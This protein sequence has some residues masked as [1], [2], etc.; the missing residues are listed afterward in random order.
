MAD[1]EVAIVAEDLGDLLGRADQRGGVAVG[2]GELCDLG[3]QPLVDA[4]ALV[5]EREQTPRASGG[6]A[7]GGLAIAGLVLERGGARR[8]SSAFSQACFSVGAMIGRTERLKRGVRRP[9]L[10]A[11]L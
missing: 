9:C 5:G 6:M 8:I 3:P 7:V 2:A 11:A 10:T 1:A 4:A